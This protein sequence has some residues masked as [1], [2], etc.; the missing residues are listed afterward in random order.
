[1][2]SC[3]LDPLFDRPLDGSVEN[4][5][6]VF[7]HSENKTGVYHYSEIVQ[8][9][10]GSGVIPVQVLVFVLLDQV[11]GIERLESYEQAAQSAGDSFF[12]GAQP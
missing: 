7:V 4:I 8:S 11:G 1:M 2:K 10:N 5:L 12:Q 6:I 3:S 9:S